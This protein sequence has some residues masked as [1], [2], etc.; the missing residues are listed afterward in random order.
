MVCYVRYP[1]ETMN[2]NW[3]D[4]IVMCLGKEAETLASDNFW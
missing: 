4:V 1:S 3:I 2:V